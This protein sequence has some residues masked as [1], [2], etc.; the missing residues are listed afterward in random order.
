LIPLRKENCMSAFVRTVIPILATALAALPLSGIAQVYP[1]KPVRVIVPMAPGGTLDLVAR[2]L[3][4]RMSESLGQPVVVENRAGASG[5]IGAE[6]VARSAPDGYTLLFTAPST[7]ITGRFLS[8][9][10]PYDPDKD[11]TP[12]TLAVDTVQIVAAHPSFPA[13]SF[14]EMIDYAKRNPGKVAYGTSGMG[15]A[16]HFSGEQIRI[17]T[18]AQIVHVPYKGSGPAIADAV[19]GQIPMIFTG[20]DNAQPH[21]RAGK[22]K[23]LGVMDTRRYAGLPDVPAVGESVAGF[24]KAPSWHAYF[25]PA[26]LPRSIVMRVRGEVVKAMS[27]PEVRA[28]LNA[29]NFIVVG[30]TPEQFT[31]R[32]A[33][34]VAAM[35]K[36]AQAA[37]IKPE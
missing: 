29:L 16:Y 7:H 31:A 25:A 21:V 15:T 17:L 32:I 5:Y 11:F 36:V 12:I 18:G 13:N 24:E 1:A 37:G 28:K 14:A 33:R 10:L 20:V 9:N 8:R 2:L 4:P 35:R 6:A 23:F 22:L 3:A 27:V 34:E 19:A 26:E 30:D